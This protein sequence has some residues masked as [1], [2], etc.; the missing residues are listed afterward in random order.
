MWRDPVLPGLVYASR[1]DEAR[2]LEE[3]SAM[4]IID[5]E[6]EESFDRVTRLVS[7]VLEMP[8]CLVSLV[9]ADRQWFKSCVGLTGELLD[10]RSTEREAAFCQYV[11]ALQATLVVP[12]AQLDE[13]FQ[14]N[15]LVQQEGGIRFYA[16]APLRTKAGHIL[17]SLCV[18]DRQP[19]T[20][21]AQQA[22]MLEEF[23]A[24]VVTELELRSLLLHHEETIQRNRFLAT[25]VESAGLGISIAEVVNE[26]EGER[27]IIYANKAYLD[28]TGYELEEVMGQDPRFLYGP[29][30]DPLANN[31]IQHGL[32]ERQTVHVE[33]LLQRKNGEPYWSHNTIAPVVDEQ[34]QLTHTV[35]IQGDITE[36]RLMSEEYHRTR[37]QL[38]SVV[39]N[40]KEV[41]FQTDAEGNW[42]FLN[43]AWEEI[44]GFAEPESIGRHFLEFVHPDDREHNIREFLRVADGERRD[45]RDEIRYLTKSGD[46]RWMEVHARMTFDDMD[47]V[48]GM[49]GT[50]M[51][52][53]ERVKATAQIQADVRTASTLQKSMLPPDL[54]EERVKIQSIFQPS[55]IV[56]G[57]TFSY[58]WISEDKL[59]GFIVDIMGHGVAT[60]L[61]L[62]TIN[63]LLHQAAWKKKLRTLADRMEWVNNACIPFMPDGYFA[64]ALLFEFD[65]QQHKLTYV[66]AGINHFYADTQALRGTVTTNSYLLG[67]FENISFDQYELPFSPGDGFI[68]TTDGIYE[69]F[70]F[71]AHGAN[72]PEVWA[73]LATWAETNVT[74]DDATAVGLYIK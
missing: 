56:S 7:E 47:R 46:F 29:L 24:W 70:D 66:P 9:T 54:D 40:V 42:T 27:A 26:E 64:T 63:V 35:A 31:R 8:I 65:L 23:A 1:E 36:S 50:L 73:R 5:T 22:V 13:R 48:I 14:Q 11:V 39:Q 57:D 44:T 4:Q 30:T 37:R 10:N 53:D 55:Q 33:Y 21:T 68:F 38:Q 17:G 43:P 45:Y 41:I 28:I 59:Y 19:R 18:I 32:K 20:F 69:Q 61:Q 72:A 60:A 2:R 67:I 62:S 58:K 12:D 49:S 52:V 15:R 71:D 51:D 25:A 16:G 3:L 34:G 6:P 74:S